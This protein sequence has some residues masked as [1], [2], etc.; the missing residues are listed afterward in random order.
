MEVK[1]AS[2]APSAPSGGRSVS[3]AAPCEWALIGVLRSRLWLT[4]I[5]LPWCAHHPPMA[6]SLDGIPQRFRECNERD[7]FARANLLI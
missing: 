7:G 2:T 3:D 5:G 4:T 1:G 6:R